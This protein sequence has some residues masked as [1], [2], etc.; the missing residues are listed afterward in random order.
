[1][2]N[3]KAIQTE[4]QRTLDE[5]KTEYLRLIQSKQLHR[6]LANKYYL[7]IEGALEI[8]TILT[9]VEFQDL[10]RRYLRSK[11]QQLKQGTLKLR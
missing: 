3:R 1:M 8:F 5:R 10:H 11:A 9:D 4:L 7:G 6:D 2:K